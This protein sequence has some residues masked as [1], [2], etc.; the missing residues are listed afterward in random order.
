MEDWIEMRREEEISGLVI[1]MSNGRCE[2]KDAHGGFRV[3]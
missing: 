1:G 2:G 3:D